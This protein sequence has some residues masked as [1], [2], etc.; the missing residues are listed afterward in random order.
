MNLAWV[1]GLFEGE[2][3]IYKDPRCNS[4]RLTINSTDKDV[5][6]RFF[7]IVGVGK[8]IEGHH[9]PER[10]HYKPYWVWATHRK[11]EVKALL[12]M[13]LPMLG[14]R[15]AYTALNALDTLDGIW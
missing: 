2:G 13:M 9:A 15:R 11:A 10:Q 4:F 12:S 7:N 1:T 8:M 3:C 5:L 14:E 6:Q